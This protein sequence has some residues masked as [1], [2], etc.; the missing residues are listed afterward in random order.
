MIDALFPFF[1][2]SIRPLIPFSGYE[3]G[4]KTLS[5]DPKTNDWNPQADILLLIFTVMPPSKDTNPFII[6]EL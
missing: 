2:T 6:F 1:N 3:N 5:C 4:G